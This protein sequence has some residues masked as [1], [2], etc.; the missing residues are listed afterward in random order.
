MQFTM[1]NW[2][3]GISG[4]LSL[5][6]ELWSKFWLKTLISLIKKMMQYLNM[7]ILY[8]SGRPWIEMQN[9][10]NLHCSIHTPDE[11]YKYVYANN[12]QVYTWRHTRCELHAGRLT[13]MF[14]RDHF[15]LMPF[16]GW[17]PIL[18]IKSKYFRLEHQYFMVNH[19]TSI[20]HGYFISSFNIR[21]ND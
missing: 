6:F 7:S 14:L 13:H 10:W 21:P 9:I 4:S 20:F 1:Q 17:T 5:I 19:L 16:W 11:D 8:S 15:S 2:F 3:Q 12:L 18:G